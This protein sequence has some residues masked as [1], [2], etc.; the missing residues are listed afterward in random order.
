LPPHCMDL[1]WSQV[2]LVS[3]WEDLTKDKWTPK[4]LWVAEQSIQIKMP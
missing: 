4:P 2:Q 3:S 1:S